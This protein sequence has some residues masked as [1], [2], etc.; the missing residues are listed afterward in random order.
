MVLNKAIFNAEVIVKIN[1]SQIITTSLVMASFHHKPPTYFASVF[2]AKTGC[3]WLVNTSLK[4]GCDWLVIPHRKLVAIGPQGI[5]KMIDGYATQHE[6]KNRHFGIESHLAI[7]YMTMEA[8][9]HAMP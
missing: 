6:K 4:T 8:V 5:P 2:G 3:D 9:L 7:H 1:F